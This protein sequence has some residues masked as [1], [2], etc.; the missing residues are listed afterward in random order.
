MDRVKIVVEERGEAP[1][2]KLGGRI[3]GDAVPELGASLRDV[4]QK[5]YSQIVIDLQDVEFLDST[6][7]GVLM[8][9]YTSLRKRGGEM[10]LT[11]VPEY[12]QDILE[13]TRLNTL[14]HLYEDNESA[15]NAL[16]H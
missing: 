11:H 5:G 12:I 13:I 2:I 15:F 6:A 9:C 8:G 3:I 14:F 16:K 4:I 1:L 7:I 10:L